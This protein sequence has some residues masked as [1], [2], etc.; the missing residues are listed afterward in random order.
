MQHH[1]VHGLVKRAGIIIT[2]AIFYFSLPL[3]AKAPD[4]TIYIDKGNI[5]SAAGEAIVMR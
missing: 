2:L 5:Y 1:R 4:E 3:A